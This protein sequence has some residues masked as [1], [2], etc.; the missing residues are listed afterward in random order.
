MWCVVSGRSS[1][2]GPPGS[3]AQSSRM[4]TASAVVLMPTR[5]RPSSPKV[6][7][8][9][10]A[11]AASQPSTA[12]VLSRQTAPPSASV[13]TTPWRTWSTRSP[14]AI[15]PSCDS[16]AG[17]EGARASASPPASYT[18]VIGTAA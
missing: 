10:A 11:T 6:F 18:V 4:N 3:A 2:G 8:V 1:S 15:R 16:A 17:T 13:E 12:G 9:R 5:I 7:Q 14:T